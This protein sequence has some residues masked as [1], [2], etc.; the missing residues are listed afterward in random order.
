MNSIS[1]L[2]GRRRAPASPSK[3]A[4][5]CA[6]PT[7]QLRRN[8]SERPPRMESLPP[9]PSGP[10]ADWPT[11]LLLLAVALLGIAHVAF[12]PPFEG[13]DENAHWSYVQQIAD[14]ARLPP[15]SDA[16][17]SRDVDSYAGPRPFQFGTPEKPAGATFRRYFAAP[18]AELN[19]PV[20]RAYR[21]G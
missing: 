14:E 2:G 10:R 12:L 7:G 1:L 17:L 4:R 8:E 15:V 5:G 13:Y 16:W 9:P 20:A 6:R 3:A 21:A 18:R 19:L 11:R